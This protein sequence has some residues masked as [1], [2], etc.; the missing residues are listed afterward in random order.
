M[1]LLS[2]LGLQNIYA[3]IFK[4]QSYWIRNSIISLYFLAVIA[5]FSHNGYYIAQQFQIVKPLSYLF[6]SVT[7]EQYITRFRPEYPVIQYANDHLKHNSTVLCLFLGNRGYYMNF[8]PIFERPFKEG[9]LAT[10]LFSPSQ[11][12]SLR[13]GLLGKE[14]SHILLRDDLTQNGYQQLSKSNQRVVSSFF[15]N[16]TEQLF[17]SG[18]YTIYRILVD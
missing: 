1:V 10:I 5:M 7:R 15:Q 14:I 16:N 4:I 12:N 6:G 2:I 3:I 13:N 8:K 18:G 9:I 11:N 17:N